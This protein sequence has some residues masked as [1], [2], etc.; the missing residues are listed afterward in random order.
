MT[1]LRTFLVLFFAF[2]LIAA[3][4]GSDDDDGATADGGGETETGDLAGGAI[5]DEAAGEAK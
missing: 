5:D 1:R 3:A 4:C 2:S